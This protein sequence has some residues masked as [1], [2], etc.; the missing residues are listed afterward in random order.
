[1]TRWRPVTVPLPIAEKCISL[2][3]TVPKI[4]GKSSKISLLV[5]ILTRPP[6]AEIWYFKS[7]LAADRQP[8][9]RA[10]SHRI[11]SPEMLD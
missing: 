9:L 4:V 5:T 11:L 10:S 3:K 8:N 1:M 2:S 7:R 6:T